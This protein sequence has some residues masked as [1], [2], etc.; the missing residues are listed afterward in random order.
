MIVARRIL[1]VGL[2]VAV[3]IAGGCERPQAAV[4][5]DFPIGGAR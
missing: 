1:I 2:I 4:L 5:R 3:F